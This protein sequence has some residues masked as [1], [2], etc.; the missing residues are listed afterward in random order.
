M[1]LFFFF[2][3]ITLIQVHCIKHWYRQWNYIKILKRNSQRLTAMSTLLCVALFLCA[4]THKLYFQWHGT[5]LEPGVWLTSMSLSFSYTNSCRSLAVGISQSCTVFGCVVVS[6]FTHPQKWTQVAPDTCLSLQRCSKRSCTH[7]L[8]LL[9]CSP[10]LG[11]ASWK[12]H[13]CLDSSSPRNGRA[14]IYYL[15]QGSF[16]T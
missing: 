11:L 16:K 10:L 13:T 8:V 12:L 4:Y 7:S 3:I 2:L 1:G 5:Y 6:G 14:Y 15:F 9:S